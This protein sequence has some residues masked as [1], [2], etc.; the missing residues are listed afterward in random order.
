MKLKKEKLRGGAGDGAAAGA[1]RGAGGGAG[2]VD[3]PSRAGGGTANEL[4][5]MLE[6]L[7]EADSQL[8]K[9]HARKGVKLKKKGEL[10]DKVVWWCRTIHAFLL[11][12]ACFGRQL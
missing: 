5:Q 8:R 6:E 4:Q 1:G 3:T 11:T 2:D 10:V 12:S 9:A 7:K